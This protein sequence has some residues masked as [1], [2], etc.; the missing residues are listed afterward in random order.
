MLPVY[1]TPTLLSVKL[2]SPR[3]FGV[4]LRVKLALFVVVPVPKPELVPAPRTRARVPPAA[5]SVKR[6]L[7]FI[8]IE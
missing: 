4:T 2:D 3:W 1:P 8:K 5:P 7:K 6:K